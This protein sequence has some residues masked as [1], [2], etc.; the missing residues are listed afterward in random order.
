M[1]YTSNSDLPEVSD[2][3]L[4]GWRRRAQPY[5]I[6]ILKTGPAFPAGAPQP[7]SDAMRTIWAHGKRNFALQRAGLLPI[8]CPVA[9]GSDVA[10]IGIFD[11]TPEEVDRIMAEDPG[12]Q[13]GLFT[14]EIHATRSLPGSALPGEGVVAGER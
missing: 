3:M 9:D 8:V 4:D 11:A 10:G 5:T 6:A 7:D 12:V 14:Y 1:P 13:A 2:E